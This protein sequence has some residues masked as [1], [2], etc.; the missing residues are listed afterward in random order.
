MH[1]ITIEGET[2]NL[3]RSL[4]PVRV[5][6][7]PVLK[8]ELYE[9]RTCIRSS[10]WMRISGHVTSLVP[11]HRRGE[12]GDGAEPDEDAA[13]HEALDAQ[14]AR[15][16][17]HPVAE[18]ARD[19]RP[20]AVAHEAEAGEEQAEQQDLQPGGAARGVDELGQEREEEERRLR[21]QHVDDDSLPGEAPMRPRPRRQ[22]L[23]A[24]SESAGPAQAA[25]GRGS[26]TRGT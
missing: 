13:R 24:P 23:G 9:V 11:P 4:M 25:G 1:A 16:A 15:T 19:E 10:G 20:R 5:P 6:A 7:G 3:F 18:R 21:V 8:R 26:R 14:I 2:R 17:A 12:R 22:G